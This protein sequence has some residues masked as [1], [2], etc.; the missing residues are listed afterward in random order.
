MTNSAAIPGLAS[1]RSRRWRMRVLV[2]SAAAAL[3]IGG[4]VVAA[5]A[6]TG[7]AAKSQLESVSSSPYSGLLANSK[8]F[9]LYVLSTESGGSLH[10]TSK[11]CLATWPPYLVSSSTKKLSVATGVKGKVGFVKRSASKKQVTYNGYPVYGF[12]GDTGPK[13]TEGEG[14]VADG[15][16]W[17]L[18]AAGA[19]TSK[20]TPEKE[21][22]VLKS[23][24]ATPYTDVLATA[25]G[26]SLYALSNESTGTVHCNGGCLTIWPPLLV[27][28]LTTSIEVA[29]VI[30]GT[31]GFIVRSTTMKQVTFNGF[32]VYLYAGDAAPAQDNGEGI[33]ADGGTWDLA[34]SVATTSGT[35]LIPPKPSG[36]ATGA[37]N[38]Y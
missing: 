18:V 38:P 35:T 14:I 13:Q 27:S 16:T 37:T 4:T 24:T 25:N 23:I 6:S 5:T 19:T 33:V 1:V 2:G 30:H 17:T 3:A 28:K 22:D 20:S 26:F 7:R 11:Q 10:C 8:G 21:K 32:P 36:S 29:S 12:A 9:T 34:S 31:I 15:G